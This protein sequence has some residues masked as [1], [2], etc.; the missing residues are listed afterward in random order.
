MRI[1]ITPKD[2]KLAK[3][4]PKKPR[5]LI[6]KRIYDERKKNRGFH[7]NPKTGAPELCTFK[8]GK[9]RIGQ[10]I[11]P[12][13]HIDR[14]SLDNMRLMRPGELLKPYNHKINSRVD[15]KKYKAAVARINRKVNRA[16]A[17]NGASKPS[18]NK[19]C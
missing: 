2:P 7:G 9:I 10:F 5:C 6:C 11:S 14:R 13:L 16:E 17:R 19:G 3:N 4:P 8:D 1:K 12:L 15:I 18:R